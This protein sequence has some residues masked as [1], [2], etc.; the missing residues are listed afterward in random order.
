MHSNINE[1]MR[2]QDN[3]IKNIKVLHQKMEEISSRLE[4][5][6][7]NTSPSQLQ[8]VATLMTKLPLSSESEI[9]EFLVDLKDG[10]K[11]K[12]ITLERFVSRKI[13]NIILYIYYLQLFSYYF[14]FRSNHS[15]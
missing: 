12:N 13:K 8:N 15:D 9:A 7:N 14:Q 11:N 6:D 5:S 1:V 10:I 2:R 4:G 3:I